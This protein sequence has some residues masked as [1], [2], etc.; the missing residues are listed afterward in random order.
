MELVRS[1]E[2]D[3]APYE[4]FQLQAYMMLIPDATRVLFVQGVVRDSSVVYVEFQ[5]RMVRS[6]A[7]R[8]LARWRS[9]HIPALKAFAELVISL[10][11]DQKKLLSM[12]VKDDFAAL[13]KSMHDKLSFD[14]R[15]KALIR[16]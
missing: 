12:L 5:Q 7:G 2:V 9:D 8:K 13:L 15:R 11:A 14:F 4:E 16:L 3:L 1:R 6:Y 10:M